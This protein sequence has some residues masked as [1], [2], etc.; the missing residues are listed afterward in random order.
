MGRYHWHLL[1][2]QQLLLLL[3]EY[4]VVPKLL[5]DAAYLSSRGVAR[6]VDGMVLSVKWGA[7]EVR[8]A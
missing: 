8:V 5:D 2:L 7:V 4:I 6:Q 3:E 1:K